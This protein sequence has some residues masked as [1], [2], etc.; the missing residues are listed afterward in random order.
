MKK[1]IAIAGLALGMM[2]ACSANAQKVTAAFPLLGGDYGNA[3]DTINNAETV[4]KYKKVEGSYDAMSVQ[5]VITKISGTVGGTVTIV[6]SNDGVNFV[7]ICRA[8]VA[9]TTLRPAYKD[10]LTPANQTTNTKIWTFSNAATTE[11]GQTPAFGPYL[12]YGFKYVGTGTMS[13]TVKGYLVP[14]KQ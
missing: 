1:L 7:D 14:R 5:I 8:S 11:S 13:A 6:G 3:I 12:Y 10:T 9:A 4:T 2:L